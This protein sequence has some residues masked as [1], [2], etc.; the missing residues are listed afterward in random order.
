MKTKMLECRKAKHLLQKDVARQIGV[1]TN[2]YSGYERGVCEPS[3]DILLK[4]SDIFDVTIDELLGKS[5]P[6]IFDDARIVQ[7]EI[8]HLYNQMTPEEQNNLVGYARGL[9]SGRKILMAKN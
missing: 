1:A 4:L 9:I 2:T 5:C 8:I 6:S 7:S 3:F